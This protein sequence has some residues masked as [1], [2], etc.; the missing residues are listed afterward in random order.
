[1]AD[2]YYGWWCFLGNWKKFMHIYIYLKI[3]FNFNFATFLSSEWLLPLKWKDLKVLVQTFFIMV[4]MRLPPAKVQSAK[5]LLDIFQLIIHFMDACF[6]AITGHLM[7][8]ILFLIFQTSEITKIYM[9]VQ[10]SLIIYIS[11]SVNFHI[12][13]ALM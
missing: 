9:F 6:R 7:I 3:S 2:F 10:C 1:M 13:N 8:C 11:I 12:V 4:F 5:L